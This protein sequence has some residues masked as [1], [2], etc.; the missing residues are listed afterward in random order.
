MYCNSKS[1]VPWGRSSLL[2]CA[3]LIVGGACGVYFCMS[4]MVMTVWSV[5]CIC[6]CFILG[7][8]IP[9]VSNRIVLH[10]DGRAI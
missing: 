5:L 4:D 10:I 7:E 2:G 3:R 6:A 9:Y 1:G 8:S